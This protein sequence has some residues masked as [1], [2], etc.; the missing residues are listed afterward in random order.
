VACR[1]GHAVDHAGFSLLQLTGQ[2]NTTVRVADEMT[3]DHLTF[4]WRGG[5]AQDQTPLLSGPN[6][7]CP[8]EIVDTNWTV[9]LVW[10]LRSGADH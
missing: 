2:N 6:Q 8:G 7:S 4:A 5:G 3:Q 9:S 10:E 1:A